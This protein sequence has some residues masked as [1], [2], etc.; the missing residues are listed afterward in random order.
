VTSF[1]AGADFEAGTVV[2]LTAIPNPDSDF[3]GWSGQCSGPL[4]TCAVAIASASSVNA[5][6]KLKT[7]VIT[8]AAGA[9]GSITPS[10]RVV[11]SHGGSRKFTFTPKKGYQ[12]G[13]VKVDGVPVGKTEALF[14]GNIM[15]PHRVEATFIPIP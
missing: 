6:F 3:A 5:L 11:V 15:R 10:G 9:N 2:T 1:P 14:L 4:P 7:F 8:A 13:Q 12:V